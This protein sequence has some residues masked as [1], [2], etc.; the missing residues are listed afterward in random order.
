MRKT[1]H[2]LQICLLTLFLFFSAQLFSETKPSV[3]HENQQ[4][5]SRPGLISAEMLAKQLIAVLNDVTTPT[6]KVDACFFPAEPFYLLKDLKNAKSYFQELLAGFKSHITKERERLKDSLPLEFSAFKVGSCK[7]K[8]VGSEYNKIPYWSCY[9]NKILARP[10]S[11]DPAAKVPPL[12]EIPLRV[13]I[14]WGTEWYVT[15]F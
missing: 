6:A 8:A 9:R 10:V 4:Q 15:H 13:M 1:S 3:P 5:G 11:K 14:N 12:N 7:W 2:Y